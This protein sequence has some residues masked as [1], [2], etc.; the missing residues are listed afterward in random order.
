MWGRVHFNG[1]CNIKGSP[2]FNDKIT[3]SKGWDPP[4]GTGTNGVICK[5]G[6]ETGVNQIPLPLETDTLD[7]FPCRDTTF[8]GDWSFQFFNIFFGNDDGFMLARSGLHNFTG[9][10]PTVYFFNIPGSKRGVILVRGNVCIRGV[11]DGHITIGATG[12]IH[13]D[14]DLTCAVNPKTTPT[15]DDIIGIVALGDIKICNISGKSK[16]NW[17]VQAVMVTLSGSVS[18]EE[19]SGT[20]VGV[21][22]NYGGIITRDRFDIAQYT[23]SSGGATPYLNRGFY[24]RLERDTRLAPPRRLRPPCFPVPDNVPSALQ[25]VNWWENVRVP[26]F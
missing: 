25:I 2:V 16:T 26:E 19:L 15:S 9:G 11:V 20:F 17:Y 7:T 24:R 13:I 10:S 8:M 18:A 1:R 21:F 4:A 6:F 3:L 12:A 22:R 23:G 5:N 14:D